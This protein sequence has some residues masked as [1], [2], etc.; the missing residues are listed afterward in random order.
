MVVKDKAVTIGNI[1]ATNGTTQRNKIGIRTP[2][3]ITRVT[4]RALQQSN[5]LA[6]IFLFFYALLSKIEHALPR[7]A[8]EWIERSDTHH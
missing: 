8:V 5:V 2:I 4:L 6:Q 1:H 3:P 7:N